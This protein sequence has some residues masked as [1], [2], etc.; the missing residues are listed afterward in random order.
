M[1]CEYRGFVKY[2]LPP[3]IFEIAIF[4]LSSPP[5]PS[6][7]PQ[8]PHIDKL[9]HFLIYFTLALLLWRAFYYA[10][11]PFFKKNAVLF[12]FI[13]TIILG[14]SDEFHQFFVPLRQAEFFDVVFD[15]LGAGIG[16]IGIC[17]YSNG[18]KGKK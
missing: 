17:F 15:S 5:S 18:E 13:L 6:I 16:M 4:I 12:A 7:G 10:S 1:R 8:I 14:V 3:I 9:Y 11:S 2:W